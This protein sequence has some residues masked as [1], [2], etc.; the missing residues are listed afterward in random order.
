MHVQLYY[1]VCDQADLLFTNQLECVVFLRMLLCVCAGMPCHH[2]GAVACGAPGGLQLSCTAVQHVPGDGPLQSSCRRRPASA[3]A[4]LGL[5][6]YKGW[7]TGG[8]SMLLLA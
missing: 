4:V 7:Y 2:L 8:L 1:C 6:G 5:C 3:L